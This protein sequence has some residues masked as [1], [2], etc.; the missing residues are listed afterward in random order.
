MSR[1][2]D[3]IFHGLQEERGQYSDTRINESDEVMQYYGTVSL[4]WWPVNFHIID[5]GRGIALS[6]LSVEYRDNTLQ[7]T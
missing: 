5:G 7:L 2:E 6:I 4:Y 3:W 1:L